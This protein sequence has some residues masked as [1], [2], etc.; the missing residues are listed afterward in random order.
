MKNKNS[1][2]QEA[3]S[4]QR[5]VWQNWL[6]FG[7]GSEK[8]AD[9]LYG[10]QALHKDDTAVGTQCNVFVPFMKSYVRVFTFSASQGFSVLFYCSIRLNW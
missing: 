1:I 3:M 10:A 6:Y 8:M 9:S 5:Y 7:S 4:F 2:R